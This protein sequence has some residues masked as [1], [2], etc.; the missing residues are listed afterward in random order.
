MQNGLVGLRRRITLYIVFAVIVIAIV[1]FPS[2][3]PTSL[4]VYQGRPINYW[5]ADYVTA[6]NPPEVRAHAAEV[7]REMGTNR[8][9]A[10]I[11]RLRDVKDS[12][13]K[14]KMMAVLDKQSWVKFSFTTAAMRREAALNELVFWGPGAAAAIPELIKLAHDTNADLAITGLHALGYA[15]NDAEKPIIEPFIAATASTNDSVR[16]TGIMGVAGLYQNWKQRLGPSR[17]DIF[18]P[19]KVVAVLLA[20]TKDPNLQ[21]RIYSVDELSKL[22]EAA[23]A[24][25][26]TLTGLLQSTN[27]AIRFG[28]A[29]ALGNLGGAARPAV[30]ALKVALQDPD[31]GVRG[32]VEITLRRVDPSGLSTNVANT[33]EPPK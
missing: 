19:D 14:L 25:V 8:T 29:R 27:S 21:I 32:Q 28:A 24:I 16:L 3:P 6:E 5:H 12:K 17:S 13:F 9:P 4:P 7:L 10:L 2:S 1:L 11:E 20:G 18:P 23:D 30:P 15:N 33:I 26:P 31:K 22:L